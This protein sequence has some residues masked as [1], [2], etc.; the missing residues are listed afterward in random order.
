MSTPR[1]VR[2]GRPQKLVIELFRARRLERMHFAALRVDPGH[3]VLDRAV[4]AAGIHRLEDRE[5]RPAVIG[6][7]H[8]LQVGE[9]L[10]VIG[11]HRLRLLLADVE[12]R[13]VRR[14]VIGEPE[15]LGPLDAERL[16]QLGA[17]HSSGLSDRPA[18]AACQT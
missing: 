1:E 18:C 3:H 15:A 9:A 14:V 2:C 16:D 12:P 6:V 4:L 13:R 17:F 10:D 7:E 5:H 8:F 11:E